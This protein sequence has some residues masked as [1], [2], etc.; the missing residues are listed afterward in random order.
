MVRNENWMDCLIPNYPLKILAWKIWESLHRLKEQMFPSRVFPWSTQ[1]M[2]QVQLILSGFALPAG[3]R[4]PV[5][6]SDGTAACSPSVIKPP[7]Q[8]WWA[9]LLTEVA[10]AAGYRLWETCGWLAEAPKAGLSLCSATH[11]SPGKSY[12]LSKPCVPH[13]L[14]GNAHVSLY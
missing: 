1:E 10:Q 8:G 3:L 12:G 13:I 7:A 14:N 11:Q 2:L 4:N 6:R 9:G 5:E